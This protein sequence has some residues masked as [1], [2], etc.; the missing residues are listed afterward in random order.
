MIWYI[1][2]S[3]HQNQNQNQVLL[4]INE[5][6]NQSCDASVSTENGSVSQYCSLLV[7]T[8]FPIL[9]CLESGV[10]QNLED[11]ESREETSKAGQVRTCLFL[12]NQCL[13]HVINP[14]KDFTQVLHKVGVMIV[15]CMLHFMTQIFKCWARMHRKQKKGGEGVNYGTLRFCL[16]AQSV[17]VHDY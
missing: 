17:H 1:L 13:H 15:Y 3:T 7:L 2:S 9:L 12:W 5:L 10:K 11:V 6:I 4:I 8:T 16:H 14:H